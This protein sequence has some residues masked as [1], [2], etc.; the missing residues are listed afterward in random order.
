MP[1]DDKL[2]IDLSRRLEAD[3]DTVL[4]AVAAA[5]EAFQGHWDPNEGRISLSIRAGLRTGTWHGLLH[6]AGDRSSTHL[7]LDAEREEYRVDHAAFAMLCLSGISA[8]PLLLWPFFPRLLALLPIA[9][10]L[11]VG[12][13]L[14]VLSRLQNQG[15]E[16]FLETVRHLA[17]SPEAEAALPTT[18]REEPCGEHSEDKGAE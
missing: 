18:H 17:E 7:R 2:E 10:V 15:P 11:A 8:I 4:Q 16:E 1:P 3:R 6:L 5:A 13:W 9:L 12:G 14:L